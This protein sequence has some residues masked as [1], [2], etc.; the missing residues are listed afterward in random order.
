MLQRLFLLSM[1]L[2]SRFSPLLRGR[3]RGVDDP[4]LQLYSGQDSRIKNDPGRQSFAWFEF[5]GTLDEVGVHD[6]RAILRQMVMR[7]PKTLPSW[8]GFDSSHG[9][10]LGQLLECRS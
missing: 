5:V 6:D 1:S 8:E 7:A 3:Y 9:L 4:S 2:K 10:W